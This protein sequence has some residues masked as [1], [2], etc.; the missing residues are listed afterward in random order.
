[1]LTARLVTHSLPDHAQFVSMA[2]LGTQLTRSAK[3]VKILVVLLALLLARVNAHLVMQDTFLMA[4]FATLVPLAALNVAVEHAQLVMLTIIS[5]EPTLAF[6]VLTK[7][8]L[9]L[10]IL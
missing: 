3:H 7:P 2:T 6:N 5:M 4:I 9:K 1:M 10:T 8:T